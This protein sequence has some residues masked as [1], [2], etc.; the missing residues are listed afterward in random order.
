MTLLQQIK[1][2]LPEFSRN[3][4]KIADYIISYPYDLQR[5]NSEAFSHSCDV[6]RSA[7]VRFCHKL[8]FNGYSDFRKAFLEEPQNTSDNKTFSD[9]ENTPLKYYEFLLQGIQTVENYEIAKTFAN[10][11]KKA[12]TILCFGNYHSMLSAKQMAFRLL[13]QGKSAY[14]PSDLSNFEF[15]IKTLK[16][17]DIL[18][19]FSI[20]ASDIYLEHV[21]DLKKKGV[22]VLLFTM[23]H[24][25]KLSLMCEDKL[26]LPSAIHLGCQYILDEAISFFLGIELVMEAY[27]REAK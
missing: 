9:G 2:Q 23:D 11:I 24:N 15:N 7:I 19:I 13:R 18:I 27:F 14:V 22:T 5:L 12:N 17:N 1:E 16:K 3:E 4:R 8:G 25:S 20:S 26:I 6:S 10:K 21:E